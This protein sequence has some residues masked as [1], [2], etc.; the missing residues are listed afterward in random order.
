MSGTVS[1]LMA[2]LAIVVFVIY[3]NHTINLMRISIAI[4]SVA[5]ETRRAVRRAYPPASA[6]L[7]VQSPAFGRLRASWPSASPRGHRPPP[8]ARTACCRASMPAQ[9]VYLP[10]RHDCT[11]R[12]LASVGDYVSERQPV[13]EIHWR[14]DGAPAGVPSDQEILRSFDVGPERT[15]LQDPSYGLRELV[16]VGAQALSSAVNAP[17]TA[18]QVIDRLEDI[19]RQIADVPEPTGL[20]ADDRGDVRLGPANDLMGRGPRPRA[21]RDRR[22]GAG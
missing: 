13:A 22:Y 1:T 20:V 2:I 15:L 9:L 19:L 14:A 17:T 11:F 4:K 6:Y 3:V 21:H 7:P 10:R 5:Q 8:G 16:D 12:M 18:M